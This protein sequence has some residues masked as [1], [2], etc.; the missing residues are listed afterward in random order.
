[1]FKKI[2]VP[3]DGSTCASR[4]LDTATA[5]AG[6]Q[7]AKVV[8]CSVMEPQNAE[9]ALAYA[10]PEIT[11]GLFEALREE[12]E[13]DLK[14]GCARV[15]PVQCETMLRQGAAAEEIV[16]AADACGADLIVMGS[17]GRRGLSRFFLGSVAEGVLRQAK[18]PVM[19]IRLAPVAAQV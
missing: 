14:E 1:M 10:T 3:I 18:V 7:Q 2:L 9:Y 8:L 4:A 17:H 12:A 11:G 16:K 13:A 5:L 15:A 19:I 6:E